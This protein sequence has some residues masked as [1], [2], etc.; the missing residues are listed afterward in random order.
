M[1]LQKAENELFE[2]GALEQRG[3]W[4]GS[5]HML[6][7]YAAILCDTVCSWAAIFVQVHEQVEV[8]HGDG[9]VSDG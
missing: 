9:L 8:A 5:G 2:S 4:E 7:S 1:P 6:T 3:G